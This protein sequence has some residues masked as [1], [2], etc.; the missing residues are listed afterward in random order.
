[1]TS[2]RQRAAAG[3]V[4]AVVG[5]LLVA[6]PK[7]AGA[8]CRPGEDSNEAKLL[9]HYS[10]PITFAPQVGPGSGRHRI[11][12]GADL[13]FIPKPDPALERTGVCFMPKKEST[14][15][16]PVFP[17][18]RL[19]IGLPLGMGLEIGYLPPVRV[20]G[21]KANL[22]SGALS[23]ARPLVSGSANPIVAAARIHATRGYVNGA[24][25][26]GEDALQQS[27]PNA[28]CYGSEKSNDTFRPNMWG[29]DGSIG[30]GF[31]DGRLGLYAGGGYT[32][33]APRFRVG[34]N[35]ANGF[36]DRTRVEVD[37]QRAAVFGGAT[38]RLA[39]IWS[40]TAQV[41]SVP[42]DVTLFRLG[43]TARLGRL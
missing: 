2:V 13:T 16:S 38:Y 19:S 8:Q 11:V 10:A 32:W 12:F 30:R 27:D 34:F 18:P 35:D 4:G 31:M 29:I 6:A 39:G 14:Q 9:A 3:L 26:C 23:I 41:Y 42:V 20:A 28:A 36:Q 15:L 24:I 17:R 37:L 21:A 7:V 43:A 22:I 5:A 33:L 40:A 1:M 25:T